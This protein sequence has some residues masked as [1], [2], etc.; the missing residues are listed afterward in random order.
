M[1][2]RGGPLVLYLFTSRRRI[3]VSRLTLW[4]VTSL[5]VYESLL[6]SGTAHSSIYRS[7]CSIRICI[8]Y[9]LKH[10]IILSMKEIYEM[11]REREREREY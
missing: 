5:N 11:D 8:F 6:R 1:R 2:P 4:L 9:Q 10:E 3:L 7:V